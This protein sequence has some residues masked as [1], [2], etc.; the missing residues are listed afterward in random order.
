MTE[1]E[2][3]DP[4]ERWKGIEE[5]YREIRQQEREVLESMSLE[6]RQA[7]DLLLLNLHEE[8]RKVGE[9]LRQERKGEGN[10]IKTKCSKN[11]QPR[12]GN[13]NGN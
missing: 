8:L 13:H 5:S 11:K 7:H 12:R 3:T 10:G 1:F 4:A 2:A 6:E 9:R